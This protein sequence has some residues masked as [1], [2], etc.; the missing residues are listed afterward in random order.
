M[1]RNTCTRASALFS[2][3]HTASQNGKMNQSYCSQVSFRPS[4][5]ARG[6]LYWFMGQLSIDIPL[7]ARKPIS[8]SRSDTYQRALELQ[9]DLVS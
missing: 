9:K 3:S 6:P 5:P 1:C 4:P 7:E 2:A 8:S